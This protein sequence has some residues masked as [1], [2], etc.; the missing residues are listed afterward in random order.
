MS[1]VPLYLIRVIPA[2]DRRMIVALAYYFP[3]LAVLH[4]SSKEKTRKQE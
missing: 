3:G 1:E 4:R 2:Q